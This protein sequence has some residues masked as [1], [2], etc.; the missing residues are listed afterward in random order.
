[1]S[2]TQKSRSTS[3]PWARGSAVSGAPRCRTTKCKSGFNHL[4]SA[5]Q[6]LGGA[7]GSEPPPCTALVTIDDRA[8][9]P[10]FV[11]QDTEACLPV[12]GSYTYM[13]ILN[14]PVPRFRFQLRET[15]NQVEWGMFYD[16]CW[17]LIEKDKQT[18]KKNFKGHT[19]VSV[20]TDSLSFWHI[21]GFVAL[22][23][24]PDRHWSFLVGGREI[25]LWS[26]V[27]AFTNYF[28]WCA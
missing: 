12:F 13:C 28:C 5:V 10:F 8:L 24:G 18:N 20:Y 21:Q 6:R 25:A 23:C 26:L 14:E 17:I 22:D 15:E 16:K 1:M 4:D 11:S 7:Q 19:M 9:L 3:S 27:L 2:H